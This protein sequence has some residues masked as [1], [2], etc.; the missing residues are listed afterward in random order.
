[1]H[2]TTFLMHWSETRY[3]IKY[4]HC[5]GKIVL[6]VT[7]N[8]TVSIFGPPTLINYQF[9]GAWLTIKVQ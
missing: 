6:K 5:E 4:R 1:M 8:K 7:D 2:I 9:G 3:V